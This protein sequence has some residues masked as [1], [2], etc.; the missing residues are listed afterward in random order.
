MQTKCFI[1]GI[2]SDY[3]DTTPHGFETH[4]LDEHNLANYMWVY[5]L[6]VTVCAR[7]NKEILTRKSF[8]RFFLMYLINKDETEHTGQVSLDCFATGVLFYYQ[9][10]YWLITKSAPLSFCVHTPLVLVLVLTSSVLGV[11]RVED[12]P[13]ALLGLLPCWWLFQKAIWGSAFLAKYFYTYRAKMTPIE[14]ILFIIPD[15]LTLNLSF[16]IFLKNERQEN[17][18][19]LLK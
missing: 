11:I 4:T 19:K 9:D 1:C 2:G 10:S 6:C 17:N 3:F 7:T 12:V 15:H 8:F 13:G 18:K 16:V 5:F 14:L